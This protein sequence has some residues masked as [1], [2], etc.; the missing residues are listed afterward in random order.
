MKKKKNHSESAKILTDFARV[1]SV[2]LVIIALA[3]GNQSCMKDYDLSEVNP[4]DNG[5]FVLKSSFQTGSDTTQAGIGVAIVF[6]LE[7]Q[8]G[9]SFTVTWDFGDNSPWE[10]GTG[11]SQK[12]HK[13]GAAGSYLLTVTIVPASGSTIVLTHHVLI[14]LNSNGLEFRCLAST[15]V[16]SGSMAG[17]Y[18][19][20]F[21]V[22]QAFYDAAW[23]IGDHSNWSQVTIANTD[24]MIVSGQ[25]WKIWHVVRYNGLEKQS[26]GD[27]GGSWISYPASV[28]WH[29]TQT[30][31]IFYCYCYNGVAYTSAQGV[32]IPGETGDSLS[33]ISPTIRLTIELNGSTVND[34]S[35]VLFFN[36]ASYFPGSD[37]FVVG[38]HDSLPGNWI[39]SNQTLIP[40]SDW[41]F[42]KVAINQIAS[43]GGLYYFRAGGDYHSPTVYG[44]MS[45]SLFYNQDLNCL[46]LQ[47]AS[48]LSGP[49]PKIYLVS[50][51]GK[52]I[53]R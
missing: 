45:H 7:N 22:R 3:W 5:G 19:Y 29:P 34:D 25:V 40:D 1:L 33:G 31:G 8:T 6:Y 36:N 43:T 9:T 13:Y 35:L 52:K 48:P 15:L 38:G 10:S 51:K 14:G 30:G 47:V 21:G 50:C 4:P 46:Y 2:L 16:T 24:T 32:N 42:I 27:A 28:Y 39:L 44:D 41:G 12:V 17:A 20:T 53:L 18:N 26:F 49:G 37:P 11:L 23:H